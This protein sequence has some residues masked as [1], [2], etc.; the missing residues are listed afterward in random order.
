MTDPII[1]S[2]SEIDTGRQCKYKHELAYVQRWTRPVADDSPLGKGVLWH[3]LIETHFDTIAAH[4]RTDG[5][6]VRWDV[7][8]VELA[9]L[10][11]SAVDTFLGD[12]L[13]EGVA[14]D[15][16]ELMQW[17]YDGYTDMWGLDGDHDIVGV[18]TTHLAPLGEIKIWQGSVNGVDQFADVPVMLKFKIDRTIRDK[19]GHVRVIDEKSHGQLPTDHDYDFLDQFGLYVWGLRKLGVNVRGAIHS[20]SKTKPNKGD[21]IKPGHPDYK[22]SMKETPLDARFKRTA[23]HYTD[24]QLENIARDALDEV[25][26]LYGPHNRKQ[27]QTDSDR[28][29]WRCSFTEACLFGRRTGKPGATI[30]MLELNGFT[31]EFERH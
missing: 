20:A 11:E 14:Q 16:I 31:Q 21:L 19:W 23:I 17:M 5:A 24:A 15:V 9:K 25:Q 29:K 10:C 30:K 3:S 28:C 22:S 13:R 8:A 27:R 6:K 2:W 1:V 7:S 12:K 26:D 4:Q 18:E